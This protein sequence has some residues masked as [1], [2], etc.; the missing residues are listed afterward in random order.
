M[1]AA[2][3][4]FGKPVIH[5]SL[6]YHY[7]GF[8]FMAG[9]R[10]IDPMA[11]GDADLNVGLYDQ[12]QAYSWLQENAAAFGG[13]ADHIVLWGQSAGAQ[14]V[15]S[16]LVANGLFH[17]AIIQSGGSMAGVFLEADHEQPTTTFRN[18]SS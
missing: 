5:V 16:Q 3:A 7:G 14:G 10:I 9:Q 6:S 17:A 13:D 4:R 1:A 8:G 12:R 18:V 11:Q 2:S 15:G